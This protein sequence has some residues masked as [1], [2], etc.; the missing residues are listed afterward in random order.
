MS[1][2]T[3]EGDKPAVDFTQTPEF[4]DAVAKAVAAAAPQIAAAALAQ[5]PA[6]APVGGELAALMQALAMNI[7]DL[8]NQGT[9]M[10][11]VAPELIRSR[12]EGTDRMFALIRAAREEGRAATYRLKGKVFLGEEVIEPS[13]VRASDHSYQ[14]TD[15][16]WDAVPN[17]SMEPLN[18]TAKEIFAAFEQSIA[19]TLRPVRPQ[20]GMLITGRVVVKNDPNRAMVGASADEL[21][22]GVAIE[23]AALHGLRIHNQQSGGYEQQQILGTTHAGRAF[24]TK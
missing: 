11:P 1:N 20:E 24:V 10:K 3:P 15:I 13:W 18:E 8:T 16:D 21:K 5:A 7:S 4:A 22:A 17:Q 19:G 2:E 12:Q 14:P 6:A 23:Q 9:G